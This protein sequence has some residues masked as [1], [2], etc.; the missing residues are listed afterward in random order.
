MWFLQ[1]LSA[2]LLASRVNAN[3]YS[4]EA[5]D[6]F[7]SEAQKI[8]GGTEEES[9]NVI[10]DTSAGFIGSDAAPYQDTGEDLDLTTTQYV[11]TDTYP[12]HRRLSNAKNSESEVQLLYAYIKL[13]IVA[14]NALTDHLRCSSTC[15]NTQIF[16]V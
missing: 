2:L 6:A 9:I 11:T 15:R 14:D 16:V 10:F 7:C 8:I 3:P 12:A 4:Q 1:A 13:K 5:L